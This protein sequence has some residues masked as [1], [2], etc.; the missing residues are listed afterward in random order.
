MS[1]CMCGYAERLVWEVGEID[2]F[3]IQPS[4]WNKRFTEMNV[5][6]IVNELFRFNSFVS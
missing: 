2:I 5:T 3:F 4:G 1:M 6:N